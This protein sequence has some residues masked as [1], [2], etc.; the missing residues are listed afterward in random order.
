MFTRRKLLGKQL[1]G[2]KA[3]AREEFRSSRLT[4]IRRSGSALRA[5]F[6]RRRSEHTSGL[7][8]NSPD[9]IGSTGDEI[10]AIGYWSET[11]Q[12]ETGDRI[13]PKG[14][15]SA[16]DVRQGDNWKIRML[17]WNITPAAPV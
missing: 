16:I 3:P 9:L 8:P 4:P 2:A 6:S 5:H 13:P 7:D 10:L 12:G 1:A 14:F 11:L 15:W 17:T